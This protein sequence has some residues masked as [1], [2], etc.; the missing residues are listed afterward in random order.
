MP[1]LPS[2]TVTFLFSDIE[3]STR[4]LEELGDGYVALLQEH[5]DPWGP[6]E[7]GQSLQ[8]INC[9][10]GSFLHQLPDTWDDLAA[11]QLGVGHEGFVGQAMTD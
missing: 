8:W 1:E 6:P 10:A 3:G 4:L 5:R 2:G 9:A 11:V 7:A